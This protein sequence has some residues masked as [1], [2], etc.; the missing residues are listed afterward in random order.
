MRLRQLT[1]A[2]LLALGL[3]ANAQNEVQKVEQVTGNVELNDAV[4]LT[5]TGTEPF[6]TMASIDIKN[7]DAAVVF[8]KVQPSTVVSTCSVSHAMAWL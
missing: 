7:P 4:D 8:E 3:T 6:A 5:I 2:W 1:L